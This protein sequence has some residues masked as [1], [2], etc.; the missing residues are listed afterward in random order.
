M[1]VEITTNSGKKGSLSEQ[2]RQFAACFG[3][4]VEQEHYTQLQEFSAFEL[5]C[6]VQH[7]EL[8]YCVQHVELSCCVQYVEQA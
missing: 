4:A 7:V 8:S 2:T 5:S 1:A 3:T 6:C